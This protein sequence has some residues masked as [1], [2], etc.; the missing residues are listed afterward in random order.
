MWYLYPFAFFSGFPCHSL[1]STHAEFACESWRIRQQLYRDEWTLV[2]NK[3]KWSPY[4]IGIKLSLGTREGN[5]QNFY[6]SKSQQ[7]KEIIKES[8]Y[9]RCFLLG[10]RLALKQSRQSQEWPNL[11]MPQKYIRCMLFSSVK[12]GCSNTTWQ[13]CFWHWVKLCCI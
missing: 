7:K 3:I 11:W 8:L 10:I 4:S 9:L 1:L 13:S 12:W 5:L 2:K 6:R